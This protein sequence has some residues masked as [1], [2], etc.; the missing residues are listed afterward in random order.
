MPSNIDHLELNDGRVYNFLKS[1]LDP[2]KFGMACTAEVRDQ[3]RVLLGMS[4]VE[5]DSY[6]AIKGYN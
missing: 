4:R 2:D 3:A 5:T 1:L 6:D